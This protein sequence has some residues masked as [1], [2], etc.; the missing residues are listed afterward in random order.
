M[1]NAVYTII[2]LLV[3]AN[4]VVSGKEFD[5]EDWRSQI[6]PLVRNKL[7]CGDGGDK[8][9]STVTVVYEGK[10]E[11]GSNSKN[12]AGTY[13]YIG[14]QLDDKSAIYAQSQEDFDKHKTSQRPVILKNLHGD[15]NWIGTSHLETCT[16]GSATWLKS[17]CTEIHINDCKASEWR[18]RGATGS[19]WI[20][21]GIT[22]TYGSGLGTAA[23][24]GIVIAVL[25]VIGL[26]IG[27][28]LFYLKRNKK[29]GTR[30]PN[31]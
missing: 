25:L 27:G 15:K 7:K 28:V 13:N 31:T 5:C 4:D 1:A 3:A 18:I 16:I 21:N 19:D 2:V 24:A 10:K 23:I 17:Y 20:D 30:V 9:I 14:Y 11:I 6:T 8:T 26:A 22:V 12:G 29:L